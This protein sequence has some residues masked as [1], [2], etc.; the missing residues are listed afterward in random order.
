MTVKTPEIDALHTQCG[1]PAFVTETLRFFR[2][3]LGITVKEAAYILGVPART[4]EG[5]EQ[6]R[7]F[8]YPALLVKAIISMQGSLPEEAATRK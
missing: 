1:N 7:E 4:L 3:Q 8:P 2:K 5:V 6:G